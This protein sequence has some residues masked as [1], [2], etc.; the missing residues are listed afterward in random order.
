M[1]NF[2]KCIVAMLEGPCSQHVIGN[3]SRQ[4]QLQ[5]AINI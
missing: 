4:N 5:S 1:E 3:T 2:E